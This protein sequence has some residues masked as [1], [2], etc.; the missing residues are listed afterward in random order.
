MKHF[1]VELLQG[2]DVRNQ[3]LEAS[4]IAAS[5]SS[6]MAHIVDEVENVSAVI[7]LP[8]LT[9]VIRITLRGP[10][11]TQW[12]LDFEDRKNSVFEWR[13]ANDPPDAWY[14]V[15]GGFPRRFSAKTS[16]DML[17]EFCWAIVHFMR[18][19]AVVE[20]RELVAA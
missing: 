15:A 20:Q 7:M 13:A 4:I 11:G 5:L 19:S 6:G 12:C 10:D 9:N 1:D 8:P 18:A 2:S 16:S 3:K 17:R 14:K